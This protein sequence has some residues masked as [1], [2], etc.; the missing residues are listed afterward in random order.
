[1]FLGFTKFLINTHFENFSIFFNRCHDDSRWRLFPV[2]FLA[3]KTLRF[4]LWLRFLD[5]VFR[6]M[7]GR[8]QVGLISVLILLVQALKLNETPP[9]LHR[10]P[11]AGGIWDAFGLFQSHVFFAEKLH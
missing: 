11:P 8:G 6:E 10:D 9:P 1:M 7:S 2:N 5:L 3:I 4:G